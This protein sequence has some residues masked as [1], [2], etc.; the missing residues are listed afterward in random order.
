VNRY[1]FDRF[2]LA[3]TGWLSGVI[4]MAGTASAQV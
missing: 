2:A 4:A 3:F 1:E